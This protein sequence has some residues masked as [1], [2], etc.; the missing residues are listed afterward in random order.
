LTLN[1]SGWLSVVRGKFRCPDSRP[2]SRR[3]SR[4]AQRRRRHR[5]GDEVRRV[6]IRHAAPLPL[7]LAG[8]LV[9]RAAESPRGVSVVVNWLSLI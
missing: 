4:V 7:K 1:S 8:K 6:E 9:A 5:A 3:V 2:C